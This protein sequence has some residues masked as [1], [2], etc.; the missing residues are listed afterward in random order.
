MKTTE[1]QPAELGYEVLGSGSIHVIVLND[2]MCDTSTW[3]GA[4]AYLDGQAF[5]WALADLRGY[6][7]SR[8]QRGKHTVE[9]CASDV[10]GA[11]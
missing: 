4:R 6:G 5:T 2:W 11:S 10:L 9:E 1:P 3:D 7:R 8:G